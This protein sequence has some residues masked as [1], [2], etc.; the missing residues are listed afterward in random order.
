[1]LE[2]HTHLAHKTPA[3]R[4]HSALPPGALPPGVLHLLFHSCVTVVTVS[5]RRPSATFPSLP[6]LRCLPLSFPEKIKA[7]RGAPCPSYLL[8][9]PSCVTKCQDQSHVSPWD[10]VPISV[11]LKP[12]PGSSPLPDC[13]LQRHALEQASFKTNS[14]SPFIS[15]RPH[16][17]PA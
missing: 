10:L 8:G 17:L 15:H 9:L 16:S 3:L 4:R 6:G 5:P 12:P 1:M 14:H 13:Y 7:L 11:C 2:T